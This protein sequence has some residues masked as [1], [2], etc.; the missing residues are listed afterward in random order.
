MEFVLT[1]KQKTNQ[2]S[3]IFKNLKNISTDVEMHVKETGIYIQGMD[4][5][6]ICLFELPRVALE[7]AGCCTKAK[8][9]HEFLRRQCAEPWPNQ[10]QS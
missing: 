5:G 3:H 10:M 7:L 4:P 8:T 2:F 6:H 1:N 9:T